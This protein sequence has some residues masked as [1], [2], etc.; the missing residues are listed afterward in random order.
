MPL[1]HA[2]VQAYLTNVQF[3]LFNGQYLHAEQ[4]VQHVAELLPVVPPSTQGSTS[5][6]L[7]TGVGLHSGL[8]RQGRPNEDNT[9]AVY[10]ELPK[11]QECFG[12]FVVADGMG[13]HCRGQEASRLAMY[14]FVDSVMP[15]L[16]AKQ[17]SGTTDLDAL[18]ISGVK[19]ANEKV[20]LRN[21]QGAEQRDL[22][23]TTMTVVLVVEDEVLIANVGDSRAYCFRPGA[24]LRRLTRDHSVVQSLVDSGMLPPEEVYTHHDRNKITRCLGIDA[25][26]E[27]DV[28]REHLHD[29]DVILL[30]SDGLWE[31]TRD[32]EIAAILSQQG[33]SS[34][35]M[36][37][38]LVYSALEGGGKDNIG[39]IVVAASVVDIA[40]L[41]TMM[42][43]SK[44][45]HVLVS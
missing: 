10:G 21:Q 38:H 34:Q 36:A 27:V 13:G 25:E 33:V 15:R 3:A 12:L 43:T 4:L 1:D 45:D 26:V 8:T 39:V 40:S 6:H 37:E 20:Y 9:F 31:M 2:L 7:S 24:G 18:L 44:P 11:T 35:Q 32:P 23:G 29:G 14:T 5:V 17:Q 19:Q 28:F 41:A 30:C 22:M 16:R 42:F